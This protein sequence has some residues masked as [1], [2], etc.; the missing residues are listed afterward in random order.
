M[1]QSPRLKI[2]K[3]SACSLN[4]YDDPNSPIRYSTTY[5]TYLVEGDKDVFILQERFG[6]ED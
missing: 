1:W 3:T 6:E 2:Q 5:H 4:E